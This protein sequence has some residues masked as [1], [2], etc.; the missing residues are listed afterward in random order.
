MKFAFKSIVAAA[1]FVAVGAASAATVQ[2]DGTD[3]GGFSVTATGSLQFSK[4]LASALALGQAVVGGYGGGTATKITV[5]AAGTVKAYSTYVIGAGVSSLS[6]DNASKAVTEVVSFGGTTQ[7]LI[8][9]SANDNIGAVGGNASIGDLDVKFNADKSVNIYGKVFGSALDGTAVNWSGLLFTVTAANV[10]GVTTFSTVAGTYNTTLANL[11][12]TTEGF[13]QLAA[14]FGLDPSGL[15]YTSLQ[16]AAGNF[17]TLTSAITVK[18][19]TAGIVPEPS[20]Y[21]LMGLGLVGMGLVA[22]RRAK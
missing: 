19:G 21:A 16:S 10:T 11:A 15:G 5:P 12:I 17:G 14:V 3:Q 22:R 18:A 1:A 20:T 7:A 13:D 2:T 9:Q 6:Y 8:V 4:N